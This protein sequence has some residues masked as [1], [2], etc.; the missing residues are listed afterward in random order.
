MKKN[1]KEQ[2]VFTPNSSVEME[3]VKIDTYKTSIESMNILGV[4]VGTTGH[5]G[6]D[7]G[8]GGRTYFKLTNEGCT[9]IRFVT[10]DGDVYDAEDIEIVL[11]GDC[12]LDT[13]CEALRIGYEVLKE[14]ALPIE[15][16][17][18]TPFEQ[19]QERF[20]LYVN[21]LCDLYR[22]TGRLNGMSE[23]RN[24]HHITGLTQLQFFEANLNSAVGYVQRT[25]CD[26]LYAYL[27]DTTKS[28]TI[29][30]YKYM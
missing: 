27:L 21:E 6:G 11:G 13:F 9:D 30:S 17:V 26:E 12:E 2:E 5:M 15:E 29:P 24:K 3:G 23:I 1:K 4:E 14:Q 7:S 19:R 25:F 28:K 8:H 10:L 18:P 20:A 16:Y 22:R